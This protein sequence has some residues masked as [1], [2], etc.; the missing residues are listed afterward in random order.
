MRT[1]KNDIRSIQQRYGIVL[2]LLITIVALMTS[3]LLGKKAETLTYP[4]NCVMEEHVHNEDCYEYNTLLSCEEDHEHEEACSEVHKQLVCETICHK[5]IAGCFQKDV[6]EGIRD[7]E[8]NVIAYEKTNVLVATKANS[9]EKQDEVSDDVEEAKDEQKNDADVEEEVIDAKATSEEAKLQDP[10]KVEEIPFTTENAQVV[11]LSDYEYLAELAY[12]DS[13]TEKWVR[14]TEDVIV[15]M[16]AKVRLNYNFT[17]LDI[18]VL[19][20]A[21]GKAFYQ[22]PDPLRNNIADGKIEDDKHNQIATAVRG[23]NNKVEFNF[24]AQWIEDMIVQGASTLDGSF[25]LM[26]DVDPKVVGEDRQFE[27]RFENSS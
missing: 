23:E 13:E 4:L 20:A 24:D 8:G 6:P 2:V 19:K 25:E 10:I 5:H 21:G 18:N 14:I 9:D 27:I 15:P 26:V 22:M 17:Q 11:D 3:M 12:Y 7:I 1:T 16:D